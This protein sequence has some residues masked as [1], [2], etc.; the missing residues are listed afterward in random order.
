MFDVVLH[1]FFTFWE[2]LNWSIQYIEKIPDI[3]L[4]TYILSR[5][6]IIYKCC[7]NLISWTPE[8]NSFVNLWQ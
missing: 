8:L 5:S 3:A 1:W 4:F 7:R 2:M 6:K